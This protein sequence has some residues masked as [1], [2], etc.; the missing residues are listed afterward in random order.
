MVGSAAKPKDCSSADRRAG[1][2][3]GPLMPASC[4]VAAVYF[5]FAYG[6]ISHAY[7]ET[8]PLGLQ[9]IVV[10]KESDALTSILS[11]VNLLA[12]SP[13]TLMHIDRRPIA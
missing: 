2:K 6:Y 8:L 13:L 12:H 3:P 10:H 9:K 11:G 1:A 4:R 5:Y 7:G